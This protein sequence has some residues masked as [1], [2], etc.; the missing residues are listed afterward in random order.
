MEQIKNVLITGAA[1]GF[2]TVIIEALL[3]KGY[4]VTGAMRDAGGRNK[5]AAETL[6]KKGVFIVEIDVTKVTLHHY[7]LI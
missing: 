1:G 3:T 2:G 5:Q 4:T 6:E 7:Y